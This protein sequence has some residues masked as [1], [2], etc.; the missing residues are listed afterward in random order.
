MLADI[1][2]RGISLVLAWLVASALGGATEGYAAGHV[3]RHAVERAPVH[4]AER[5]P[6]D[7]PFGMAPYPVPEGILWARWRAVDADI[8]ADVALLASCRADAAGCRLPGARRFLD[9]VDHADRL[10][11]KARLD[12]V[13]R[14]LNAAIHWQQGVAGVWAAP[15]LTLVTGQGDCMEYAI[16]KYVALREAHVAAEDLRIVI[17]WD[18]WAGQYHAVVAARDQRRWWLLDNR[19]TALGEDVQFWN[20]A[21]A[22]VISDRGIRQFSPPAPFRIVDK[23]SGPVT[24]VSN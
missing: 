19:T 6:A 13:N 15:L 17:V 11:G 16:A 18:G 3:R 2:G 8:S 14:A 22:F 21:P 4:A 1:R 7:E 20:Y 24:L 12:D 23:L 9:I 10:Q 5:K